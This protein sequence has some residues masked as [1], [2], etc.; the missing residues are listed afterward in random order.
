MFQKV[1]VGPCGTRFIA[2]ARR[3]GR[4]IFV[5]TVNE[6]EWMEWSIRKELDGV[7][8]DDPKLY[9]EVCDRW[10]DDKDGQQQMSHPVRSKSRS[11]SRWIS[12]YA[13]VVYYQ[14]LI[15]MVIT[16]ALFK[17]RLKGLTGKDRQRKQ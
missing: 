3:A 12:L 9:L 4:N 7:I 14:F 17:S 8:S 6:E 11:T 10:R 1:L 16:S 15:T 5:W 13:S 2:A